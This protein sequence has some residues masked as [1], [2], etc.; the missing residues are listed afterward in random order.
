M[1]Q[2]SWLISFGD[3]L[4]LL[5]CVF[6]AGIHPVAQTEIAKEALPSETYTILS[7]AQSGA[8]NDGIPI[9]NRT[10]VKVLRV[11]R[12]VS[13]LGPE[14]RQEILRAEVAKQLENPE[15]TLESVR[16]ISCL[17]KASSEQLFSLAA[18]IERQVVDITSLVWPVIV[19]VP[20]GCSESEAALIELNF[21]ETQNGSY[22]G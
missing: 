21:N 22:H 10:L 20:D 1:M 18:E 4:T 8:E 6:I 19:V 9:A 5:T 12:D 14:K 3:L 16:I 15:V 13:M 7:S 17:A 11:S 2:S